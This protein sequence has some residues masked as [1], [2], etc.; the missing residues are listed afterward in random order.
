MARTTGRK[1]FPK[2]V[3]ADEVEAQ[4][5]GYNAKYV[6]ALGEADYLNNP[7][8]WE[9]SDMYNPI[10][11][12]VLSRELEAFDNYSEHEKLELLNHW[13][14]FPI[15]YPHGLHDIRNWFVDID[16]IQVVGDAYYGI[17]LGG[18]KGIRI[19]SYPGKYPYHRL[20]NDDVSM[21]LCDEPMGE[22]VK[23]ARTYIELSSDSE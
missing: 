7:K 11:F 5:C 2:R 17:P 6:E 8:E 23:K 1:L 9:L 4:R 3:W 13:G 21:R 14:N 19:G 10:P 18:K 15:L 16:T 22:V 20:R 12:E